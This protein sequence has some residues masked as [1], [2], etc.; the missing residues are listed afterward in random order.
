MITEAIP[1]PDPAAIFGATL[2]LWNAFKKYY[3]INPTPD[4]S[5]D[6]SGTDCAMRTV[7]QIGERFEQ[8]ACQNVDF[9]RVDDVWPYLLEDK[10]GDAAL[11]SFKQPTKI[12]RLLSDNDCLKLA[13]ALGLP[14]KI[15]DLD[16]RVAKLE[17]EIQRILKGKP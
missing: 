13:R 9:T 1:N 4:I 15:D 14:L 11:A 7:L 3:E 6:F 12:P 2:S 17:A 16:G 8:W 5:D 10:L